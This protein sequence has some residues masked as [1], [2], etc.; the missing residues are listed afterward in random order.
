[1]YHFL[2][3][4]TAKVAGTEKG[5]TEPRATFSTCFGAPFLPLAPGRYAAMLGER[6]ARHRARVWLVNTGWT[7][8]SVRRR[9]AHADPFYAGDDPRR[10]RR[11]ARC[12]P[13]RDRSGLQRRRARELSRRA[14]RDPQAARDVERRR[15]PTIGRRRGSRRCSP[16]TSRRS[17]AKCRADV[18]AAA[19]PRASGTVGKDVIAYE[20]VIGL[21][22]HAQLL[23]ASKIFCGCSTAFGA[24][25]NTHVCP[26]CLGF[27]GALPVLNRMAV[28]LG[29]RAAL[30]LG[31]RINE[32]VDLRAQELLLSGSA[33]G[34][35]DLAV[36]TA[37]REPGRRSN[38]RPAAGAQARRASRASTSKKTQASRCTRASSI[39]IAR[40]TS[41]TTAAARRSSRSSPNPT[42]G[43][44]PTPPSS[45]RGCAR[46][47]SGSAST[48]ATWRRAACAAMRTSRCVQAGTE[49][50]G[51][52]AEVKNLNS[53]RFLQKALEYE[54]ERQ[55]DVLQSG[56]RV[57]QETR[58][59]DAAAGVTVSMRSKE[60]AH[61]YRYFPEPDLPPVRRRRIRRDG[62]SARRCPS[63][64][65]HAGG[66][67]WRRSACRNTTPRSS[68][69]RGMTRGV[70]RT[71]GCR[72]RAAQGRQQL[73][74]GRA[75]ARAEGARPRYLRL[76]AWRRSGSPAC[77]HS[78]TAERSAARSPRT[79]SRRCLAPDER[80]TEIV[81]AEGLTQIDDEQQIA[82]L[83][84]QVIAAMPTPSRSTAPDARRRSVFWSAR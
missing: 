45:S 22:I 25:P 34:L 47:W 11:R 28:E 1:M 73:D 69:S 54:I 41:T 51:T 9:V 46:F 64:R 20:P 10:A 16:T 12:R 83:V 18:S 63:C 29:V 79:C 61:D 67:S 19:G 27:P 40:P 32:H 66:G 56:G 30:A 70:L 68:R 62:R 4:Y 24:P 43:R 84:A 37:A 60:E 8:R 39:P 15:R 80:R 3:G 50:L 76:A 53:F 21:E 35:S 72:R 13:V 33:E 78:S 31:C 23:T 6:I 74:D 81:A 82:A 59:W 17:R 57:T 7:R 2:S 65:M 75:R 44:R 49:A 58:L 52:K 48:T 42:C 55:I 77:S 14:A 38:S 26:V 5:V 36:R 71:N